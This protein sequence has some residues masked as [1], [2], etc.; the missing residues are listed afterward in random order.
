MNVFLYYILVLLQLCS[1]WQV[2]YESYSWTKLDP[3]DEKT[4]ELVHQYFSW[5]GTDKE[6]RKFNQGKVFK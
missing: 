2:D 4:K 3:S 5:I 1:D 6:G